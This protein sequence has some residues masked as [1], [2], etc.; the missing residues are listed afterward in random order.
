M[1]Q[2]PIEVVRVGNLQVDNLKES[3]ALLNSLQDAFGYG[4]LDVKAAA[5][6]E[7]DQ[8]DRYTTD[9][10]YELLGRV[11]L[12][13]KGYHPYL[14]AV[15]DRRLDGKQLGN[16]FGS[17]RQ[18]PGRLQGLAVVST[19]GVPQLLG[20]LPQELYLV[21]ELLSFA[22]RF[23][24]GEG[25][26]HAERRGC[27]FDRKDD[28]REIVSAMRRGEV[29]TRCEE[30]IRH[31]LDEDQQ[32]AIGRIFQLI[33]GVAAADD[34]A[35]A[36][37]ARIERAT[38]EAPRVFLCHA[39]AD[40]EF[41]RSLA[42]RLID[43]GCRVWFDDWEIRVGDNI[44]EKINDGLHESDY[45]A[46]ILSRASLASEWVKREWTSMFMRG[47]ADRSV[48]VLPVLLEA[49][50]VPAILRP[51]KT[52]DFSRPEREDDA[53]HELLRAIEQVA[54]GGPRAS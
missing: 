28:K 35:A 40:K 21:F 42:G 54:E 20:P 31:R 30:A 27:V 29:C 43:A 39:S 15:V 47:A 10:I 53:L 7:G 26:I 13:R 33:R 49:V 1:A 34:P 23:L 51:L 3:M 50:E 46:V 36:W 2:V 8:E 4:I 5:A 17:L 6:F 11:Q 52:A 41:V 19:Y 9:E 18:E 22:V 48:K 16:L 37:S 44:V 14:L 24:Y 32:L 25:L 38:A 45:L 12:H